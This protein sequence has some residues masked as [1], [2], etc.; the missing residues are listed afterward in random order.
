MRKIRLTLGALGVALALFGAFRLVTQIPV[1]DLVV[2]A[3]WL[4]LAVAIHDGLLSPAVIAVGWLVAR[5]TPARA[6]R[7][8]QSALVGGGLIS[9]IA[10]PLIYREGSQPA[11]KA[12]LQQ[13]YGGNLSVLLA[14]VA[15]ASVLAYAGRVVHDHRT[16]ATAPGIESDGREGADDS[17]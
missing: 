10:I 15:A 6:G 3:V 8:V 11:D 12:I 16:P 5:V 1:A 14:I 2:L 4:I 17:R 9:V 7:Y 13:N